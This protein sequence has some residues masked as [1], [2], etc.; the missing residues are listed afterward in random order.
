M[1]DTEGTLNFKPSHDWSW[2]FFLKFR[3]ILIELFECSQSKTLLG[4]EVR[5][6]MIFSHLGDDCPVIFCSRILLRLESYP[7]V[8]WKKNFHSFFHYHIKFYQFQTINEASVRE[9]SWFVESWQEESFMLTI[10]QVKPKNG[11]AVRHFA[12]ILTALK[13]T[14][15]GIKW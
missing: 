1:F 6:H 8:I 13:H 5:A 12:R 4:F 14:V 3:I 9:L 7:T 10:V 2:K 15:K 11:M